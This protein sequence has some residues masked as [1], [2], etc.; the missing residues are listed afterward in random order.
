MRCCCQYLC[1]VVISVLQME[2]KN[3]EYS[4][5]L[6]FF[7][8]A[9]PQ[10]NLCLNV[11]KQDFL[12]PGL[13][14]EYLRDPL[15]QGSMRRAAIYD[16]WLFHL[17][18]FHTPICKLKNLLRVFI[19]VVSLYKW[20]VIGSERNTSH[21][22]ITQKGEGLALIWYVTH[23]C[24]QV[25]AAFV[26]RRWKPEADEQDKMSWTS[27]TQRELQYPKNPRG[28][29]GVNLGWLV[30]PYLTGDRY[31]W[32]KYWRYTSSMTGG[33]GVVVVLIFKFTVNCPFKDS[34]E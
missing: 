16:K 21:K 33:V 20:G 13:N 8:K 27:W 15:F 12:S 34:E 30:L 5:R 31:Q 2:R 10:G 24:A 23:T 1:T 29:N 25:H 9:V 17:N 32:P 18:S 6:W 26:A 28:D 19:V 11:W 7:F 22:L 3:I 4:S 14:G